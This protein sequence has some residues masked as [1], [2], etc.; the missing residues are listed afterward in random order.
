MT[1]ESSVDMKTPWC[2][3]CKGYTEYTTRSSGEGGSI[4]ICDECGK[5]MW[6]ASHSKTSI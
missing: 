5:Q 3:A 1:N 2:A 6:S 4:A